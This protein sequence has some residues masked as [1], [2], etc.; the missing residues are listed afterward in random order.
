MR[1]LPNEHLTLRSDDEPDVVEAKLAALVTTKRFYLKRPPQPF[2]GAVQGRHFKVVRAPRISLGQRTSFQPVI[3]GDIAPAPSGTEIRLRM[4]LSVP[5]AVAI[6][7]WFA[8]LLGGAAYT[9]LVTRQTVSVPGWIGLGVL[10][11]I[12]YTGTSAMFWPE[13]NKARTALCNGLGC[14]VVETSNRLVR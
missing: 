2:R 5:D 1:L 8:G 7:F 13:V 4:R 11:L 10:A 3:I 12:G 14:R 6:S 9:V